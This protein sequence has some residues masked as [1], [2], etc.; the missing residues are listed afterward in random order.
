MKTINTGALVVALALTASAQSTTEKVL[1][2]PQ[3]KTDLNSGGVFLGGGDDCS[4]PTLLAGQG[5]DEVAEL[6]A[7][8]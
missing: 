2:K 8:Y 4:A 5:P 7:N 3:P 6:R 1:T